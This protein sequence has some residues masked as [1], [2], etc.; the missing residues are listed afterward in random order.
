[1]SSLIS[2]VMAVMTVVL[3]IMLRFVARSTAKTTLHY[4]F[5]A[6]II[7][8][9]VWNSA[10]LAG[11]LVYNDPE[12]FVFVDNFTYVGAVF[13][14]VTLLFLG[15]AYQKDFKGFT[16][17]YALLLVIPVL[18]LI[19]IFSNEAHNLFYVSYSHETG[20]IVGPLFYI[21]AV[22][23]YVCMIIGMVLLCYAAAKA[24][25]VLSAQAILNFI[26]SMIPAL[27]N[28]FYTLH[29]PGFSVFT[30][31]IAFSITVFLLLISFFRYDFLKVVPIATQTV[32]NRIS[33]CF[34]VINRDMKLITYNE[35][36][37]NRFVNRSSA[38]QSNMLNELLEG[39]PFTSDQVGEVCWNI[40]NAFETRKI[41]MADISLPGEEPLYYTVEYTP[42]NEKGQNPVVVVLF[43][44]I[45]QHVLDLRALQEN[46]A[47]LLERE[48]LA[49]LGQMIGGIAH[50][51]KSPILSISGGIDEVQCLVSEYRESVGDPEVVPEDHQEIATEMSDWLVKMRNQLTYMSDIISTVKGQA[52]QFSEQSYHLFTIGEVL[53]RT[54]ILMQHSLIKS[55]CTLEQEIGINLEQTLYGDINSLVQILDNVIDNAIGA[56][57]SDGGVIHLM[58]EQIEDDVRFSVK[59]SGA[60]I[61]PE[62]EKL[63]FKEMTT[64]KGKHGTGLG[65]YMSYSTIKGMFRGNMWFE[66]KLGVGTTFFMQIPLARKKR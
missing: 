18:T 35:P 15:L 20:Y 56:Y 42:I 34:V 51:M 31:P 39:M 37:T 55:N 52:A 7:Q 64:T 58:I 1:M 47:I 46:Q 5:I 53:K 36:F 61:D 62:I 54:N 65:L 8:L 25:G 24:S 14:P 49:S 59:D 48:R 21:Y 23:S 16:I 50:N 3:L 27:A 11:S 30:T 66:T 40:T 17:R 19:A 45:T 22:Y 29:V 12:L 28:L 13:V 33:D 2:I 38:K 6:F 26:G 57:G 10:V 44:D 4:V 32:I 9:L 60:G 41:Q 43:K 63:L